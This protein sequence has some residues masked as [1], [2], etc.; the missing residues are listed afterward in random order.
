MNDFTKNIFPP[1]YN[2]PKP[3]N[4]IPDILLKMVFLK[5]TIDFGFPYLLVV[6]LDHCAIILVKVTGFI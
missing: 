6:G 5:M 2:G 1:P 3:G 4:I